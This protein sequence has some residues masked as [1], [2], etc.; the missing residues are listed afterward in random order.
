MQPD[1]RG[2]G[3]L[4]AT[5]KNACECIDGEETNWNISLF[6]SK[7]SKTCWNK[8]SCHFEIVL[9]REMEMLPYMLEFSSPC[10]SSPL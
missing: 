8:Y 7:W 9:E 5:Q 3:F 1:A 2:L 4:F 6:E 10:F